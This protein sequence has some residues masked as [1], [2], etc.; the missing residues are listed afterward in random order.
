METRLPEDVVTIIDGDANKHFIKR[1]EWLRR[2]A[3]RALPPETL[4]STVP[5]GEALEA[6]DEWL[7]GVRSAAMNAEFTQQERMFRGVAYD[8]CIAEVRDALLQALDMLPAQQANAAYQAATE[9]SDEE[10]AEVAQLWGRA[11][12]VEFAAKFLDAVLQVLPLDGVSVRQRSNLDDPCMD[13][14]E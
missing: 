3:M 10:T 5:V 7:S 9:V 4:G 8:A 14:S 2:A 6:M 1:A 11:M 12:G 13:L